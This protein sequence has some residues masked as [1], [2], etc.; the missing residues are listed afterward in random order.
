MGDF[1]IGLNIT[2]RDDTQVVVVAGIREVGMINVLQVAMYFD[3]IGI[4]NPQY[5]T[6]ILSACAAFKP[7]D[8]AAFGDE[9]TG[10]KALSVDSAIGDV[11]LDMQL[12]IDIRK[13]KS[14]ILQLI[15]EYNN[16]R[17][18]V[19]AENQPII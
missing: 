17:G 8:N 12:V 5:I 7:A 16:N 10:K 4:T 6:A 9:R 19:N 3:A 2:Q 11:E 15:A 18:S 13:V 1:F 14:I